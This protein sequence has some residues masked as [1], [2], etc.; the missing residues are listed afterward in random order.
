M[1]YFLRLLQF[2]MKS[3]A[4]TTSKGIHKI[5]FIQKFLAQ[6]LIY[7][8]SFL[9]TK[10]N[11]CVVWGNRPTGE[12]TRQFAKKHHLPLLRLEDGFL[13]SLGLGVESYPPLSIV[14][15][16]LGIYYD[17]RSP[18][19]LEKILLEESYTEENL[20]SAQKIVKTLSF[21]QISKY[22]HQSQEKADLPSNFVLV[23]DQTFG[24]MAIV[25]GGATKE[26]FQRMLETAIAENPAQKI[27]IK[28]HPDV[29]CGKKKGYFNPSL[30]NEQVAFFTQD[31][32]PAQ[33]LKAAKKV[34][35]VTSQMGFEGL[36]LGKPVITF[37]LPWFAGWGL[38]D[39]RHPN[40]NQLKQRR[41]QRSLDNLV[42]AAYCVYSHYLSPSTGEKGEVFEVMDSLILGKKWQKTLKGT[43]F[44]LGLS[45]WKRAVLSPFFNLPHC[46]LKH[47]KN[48]NKLP[49]FPKESPYRL[50]VWGAGKE[51]VLNYAK[52]HQIPVLQME[53]GFIRSVGLGSNLTAPLSLVVDDLG[54]YFDAT[55]PS[56]LEHILENKMFSE[57]EL[58][59]AQH[60]KEKL[61]TQQIG[62]YNVG[63]LV[64]LPDMPKDRTKI[65]VVGQVEDDA[66]IRL[67][68]P[69]IKSNLNLLKTVRKQ[70]PTAWICYKPH[71]D[72]VSGNRVGN[73]DQNIALQFADHVDSESNILSLMSKMD[74]LHT[75]TSLAGF[76]AL[77]R[78][79]K[80]VTYGLPFYAGWGLT[81]DH[82]TTERRTKK[83][84]LNELIFATLIDYPM[85]I[86]P[87]TGHFITAEKTVDLLT[88]L[89]LKQ[90]NNA[91]HSSFLKK[92]GMKLK[93]IIHSLKMK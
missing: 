90:K 62:K 10:K 56:R 82:L 78:G 24:D 86:S 77:L 9:L 83:R 15:D 49:T 33:L 48:I 43:I 76:E 89:K 3:I 13:R 75:L 29:L 12:K 74:E 54:I 84:S 46:Q 88:T 39:D 52:K 23:I 61:I 47:V 60:L 7:R 63:N 11:P 67:G 73:I 57:E 71:P 21:S 5:P 42:A 85:Y 93:H 50:L 1:V 26:D 27:L 80:V 19:R 4:Q 34:Y 45:P 16:D 41:E 30:Q 18:S 66:S 55:K 28:T 37:G 70:N 65:L 32:E 25:D 92:Q 36:I 22:N 44:T 69:E 20:N 58:K 81:K 35:C 17:T 87:I 8:P 64:N 91:I 53:D 40:I 68:S 79:L 6:P 38:T 2:V 72:V 59:Q 31:I 14:K 51:N